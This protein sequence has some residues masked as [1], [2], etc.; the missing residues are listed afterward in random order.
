MFCSALT[1][2]KFGYWNKTQHCVKSRGDGLVS[3]QVKLCK[4][5][6]D[7]MPVVAKAARDTIGVCQEAYKDRRWNCS[8][9]V[10]TPKYPQDLTSGKSTRQLDNVRCKGSVKACL[11]FNIGHWMRKQGPMLT[12]FFFNFAPR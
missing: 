7:L 5:N 6:L 2:N 4:Q 3:R 8:S 9:I 12:T 1:K 11:G 10:S